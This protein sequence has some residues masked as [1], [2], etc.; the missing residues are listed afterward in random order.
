[1]IDAGDDLPRNGG[2]ARHRRR[3]GGA[4]VNRRDLQAIVSPADQPL[5]EIRALQGGF[6]Q[7]SPALLRGGGKLGGQRQY[8]RQSIVSHFR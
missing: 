7:L 6:G 3:I 5:V 4:R 2:A 8:Q 1:M